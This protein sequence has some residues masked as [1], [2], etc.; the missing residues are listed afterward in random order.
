MASLRWLLAL[1][2]LTTAS[3]G[4]LAQGD[5]RASAAQAARAMAEHRYDEAAAIYRELLK[6]TPDEPELHANLGMALAMGGHEAEAVP[7]LERAIAQPP[8][9]VARAIDPGATEAREA[10]GRELVAPVVAIRDP[11]AAQ[12]Q[13][14]GNPHR[15]LVTVRIHDDNAQEPGAHDRN[16]DASTVTRS[17][18][19]YHSR[20]QLRPSR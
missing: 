14:P 19:P 1:V 3:A 7:Q 13:L 12:P 4:V 17:P 11:C 6:V 10:L 8:H 16:G 5:N 15:L 9:P 18:R 20:F 2:L